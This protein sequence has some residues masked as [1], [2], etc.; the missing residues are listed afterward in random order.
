[1]NSD[2][3]NVE[4]MTFWDTRGEPEV[5]EMFVEDNRMSRQDSSGLDLPHWEQNP[6]VCTFFF[7]AFL[8][9]HN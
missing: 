4:T 7:S 8:I 1:M 6:L 9:G 2:L 5:A 3:H